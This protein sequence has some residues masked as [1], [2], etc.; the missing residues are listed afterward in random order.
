MQKL[1]LNVSGEKKELIRCTCKSCVSCSVSN[2]CSNTMK[3]PACTMYHVFKE[4]KTSDE[5]N[6]GLWGTFLF[7]STVLRHYFSLPIDPF[8]VV[9]FS[10]IVHVNL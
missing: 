6:S 9:E 7:F 5:P 2:T 1:K 3:G 8:F 10:P 4:N